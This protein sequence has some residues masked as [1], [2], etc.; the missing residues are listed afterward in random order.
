MND[1]LRS[2]RPRNREIADLIETYTG[3]P[4]PA[5]AAQSSNTVGRTCSTSCSTSSPAR[6]TLLS[7]R[8]GT[9]GTIVLHT[10]AVFSA[11]HEQSRPPPPHQLSLVAEERYLSRQDRERALRF[12]ETPLHRAARYGFL[13]FALILFI[14]LQRLP[15][16][17]IITISCHCRFWLQNMYFLATR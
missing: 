3:P 4:E 12:A 9:I 2:L 10:P 5:A 13:V 7:A 16:S 6:Q 1:L 17:I 8:A 15:F 14:Q 11:T